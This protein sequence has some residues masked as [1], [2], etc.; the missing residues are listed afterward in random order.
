MLKV[1]DTGHDHY[2][3]LTTDAPPRGTL[4]NIYISRNYNHRPTFCRWLYESI[5][6]QIFVVGWG[7]I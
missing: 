5:F 2:C 1:T 6:V 7:S 4:T 3:R